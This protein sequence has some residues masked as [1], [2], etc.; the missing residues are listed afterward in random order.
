M[1]IKISHLLILLIISYSFIF[2]QEPISDK[3]IWMLSTL[4]RLQNNIKIFDDKISHY[5]IE[6]SKCD[7]NI[8]V[9]ENI[10]SAAKQKGNLKA[11]QTAMDALQKSYTAKEKNISLRNSVNKLK[12]QAGEILSLVRNKLSGSIRNELTVE[13]VTLK[14]TGDI[15][16]RKSNGEQYNLNDSRGLFIENGDFI[17]TSANSK[18]DLQFLGGRGDLSIGENSGVKFIKSDSL[19]IIEILSGRIK[20]GVK[21]MEEFEKDLYVKYEEY[22]NSLGSLPPLE[23]ILKSWLAK[24]FK[25][26][27]TS[28]TS[29]IRGT[30]FILNH[31][32]NKG[33]EIIVLKGTVEMTSSDGL[34][35]IL[36]NSSYKGILDINGRVTSPEKIDINTIQKWWE[37]D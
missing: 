12:K 13:A 4:T 3:N 16:I 18:I 22:K 1:N 36:L 29:A 19:D 9:S 23:D 24:K 32:E 31:N 34:E 26:K 17:S 25:M 37:E 7:R 20:A 35:S 11:E 30:E 8:S 5:E 27:T 14:Y 33:T 21:K 10:I 28:G 2:A 6:I 15:S